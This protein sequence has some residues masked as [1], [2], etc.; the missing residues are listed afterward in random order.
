VVT[1][2]RQACAIAFGQDRAVLAVEGA[3]GVDSV[4]VDGS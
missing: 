4:G 1:D 3:E 2:E